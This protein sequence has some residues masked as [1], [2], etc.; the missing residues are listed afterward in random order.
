MIKKSNAKN[1]PVYLA[2][3]V[4]VI[5]GIVAFKHKTSNTSIISTK[6]KPSEESFKA[7]GKDW[8]SPK[9]VEDYFVS[10]LHMSPEEAQSI[11]SKPGVGGKV[12][13]RLGDNTTMDGLI[14]NLKY[15]GFIREESALR[16]AL[17]YSTDTAPGKT[18]AL[19]I[20]NNT[21][22]TFA[23]YRISE[24]MTAWEIADELLNHPTN[25]AYDEYHYLFMP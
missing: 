25:F 6:T 24:E 21:V 14:S 1:L 20:G 12:M 16:Y 23:Y 13:L 22:D 19:K 18:Y 2:I 15:Y 9:K 8:N 5:L 11:R 10:N 4:I 3:G 17:E 7:P